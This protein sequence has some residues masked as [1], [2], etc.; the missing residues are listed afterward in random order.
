MK[1][2][3]KGQNKAENYFKIRRKTDWFGKNT[4]TDHDNRW[5]KL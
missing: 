5:I 4:G 2:I 3:E 1:D